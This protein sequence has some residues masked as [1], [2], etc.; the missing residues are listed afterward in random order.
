MSQARAREELV[1]FL[2]S[3]RR[4]QMPVDAIADEDSLVESGL[5]DSLAVLEIMLY[6]ETNYGID[7]A[8]NG[9][10]PAELSSIS[11]ILNLIEQ[12]AL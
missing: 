8:A 11:E 7:F 4:P 10:D 1:T 6:L 5:I 3:I 9:F 12:R 2:D